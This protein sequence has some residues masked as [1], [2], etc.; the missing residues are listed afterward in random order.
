M[1]QVSDSCG[2]VHIVHK[3]PRPLFWAKIVW[4]KWTI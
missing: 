2:Q 4:V 3:S 1:L